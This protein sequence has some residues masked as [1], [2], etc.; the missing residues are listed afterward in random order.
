MIHERLKRLTAPFHTMIEANRF[1]TSLMSG[2]MSLD[3]YGEWL[4]RYYAFHKRI[5][6]CFDLFQNEALAYDLDVEMR[7]KVAL[8]EADLQSLDV[9]IPADTGCEV[10]TIGSL[11]DLFGSMYVLEGSTMGG[12]VI[13]KQIERHFGSDA[14]KS[15]FLPYR[16][17]HMEMW[18]GFLSA[19]ATFHEK[20]GEDERIVVAACATYLY[21]NKAMQ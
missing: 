14:P 9:V 17:R 2:A 5:E 8:L 10:H 7:K 16:E 6:E 19:L 4:L 11:H 20:S 1:A 12:M 3:E 15:Y 13:A 18:R 21:L